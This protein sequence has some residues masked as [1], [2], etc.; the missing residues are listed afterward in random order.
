MSGFLLL[1][2]LTMTSM[3]MR[4]YSVVSRQVRT[5]DNQIADVLGN[6]T[7]VHGNRA[8]KRVIKMIFLI[9]GSF[10][11]SWLPYFLFTIV[12]ITTSTE[13]L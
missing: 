1:P 9:F 6:D 4:M 5:I 7:N 12:Y 2:I 11:F 10:L 8:E 3:Y 13:M